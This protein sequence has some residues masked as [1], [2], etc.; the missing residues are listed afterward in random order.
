VEERRTNDTVV[1]DPDDYYSGML[2]FN[3]EPTGIWENGWMFYEETEGTRIPMNFMLAV[4]MREGVPGA[5]MEYENWMKM[6]NRVSKS[7]KVVK[8]YHEDTEESPEQQQEDEYEA[9]WRSHQQQMEQRDRPWAPSPIRSGQR[10]QH[11]QQPM[12]NATPTYQY[13]RQ[14]ANGTPPTIPRTPVHGS[15]NGDRSSNQAPN[16]CSAKKH[17]EEE[18]LMGY[19]GVPTL[20]IEDLERLGFL[21]PTESIDTIGP[22]HYSLMSTYEG[23]KYDGYMLS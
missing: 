3:E 11:F 20:T 12:P 22:A 10:Q 14:Q 6:A 15:I 17:R 19:T 2:E 21:D 13:H 5:E 4:A 18:Y 7:L 9:R 8:E 16:G 1:D 23:N